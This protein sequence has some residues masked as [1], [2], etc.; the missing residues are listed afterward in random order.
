MARQSLEAYASWRVRLGHCPSASDCLLS[1]ATRRTEECSGKGRSESQ[2]ETNW[3]WRFQRCLDAGSVVVLLT[4][5]TLNVPRGPF[6]R[7]G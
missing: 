6:A 4:T 3:F 7:D 5:E 1:Q 2:Q